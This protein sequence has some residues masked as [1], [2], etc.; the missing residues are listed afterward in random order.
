[1]F[2]IIPIALLA[3]APLWSW[4]TPLL[5]RYTIVVTTLWTMGFGAILGL[6][7][8]PLVTKTD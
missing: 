1:L 4:F 7:W 3:D 5:E 6:C 2:A 8:P